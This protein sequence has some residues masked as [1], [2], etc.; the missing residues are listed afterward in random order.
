MRVWS[1]RHPG[2]IHAHVYEDLLA[3]PEV[4]TRALLAACGLTFDAACLRFHDAEREV[5]TASA[6]QVRHPLRTDTSIT[7][8]YGAL[9]DPLRRALAGVSGVKGF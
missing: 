4:E 1:E 7:P 5:R 6:A 9:L 2:W 8:K 3:K